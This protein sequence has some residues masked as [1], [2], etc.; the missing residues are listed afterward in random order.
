MAAI[1][2][3]PQCVKI[4]YDNFY[5]YL[6]TINTS[7]YIYYL[8]QSLMMCVLK[9]FFHF[10]T[11]SYLC[12]IFMLSHCLTYV[13]HPCYLIAI[14]EQ[15]ALVTY[16]HFLVHVLGSKFFLMWL[17]DGHP[18]DNSLRDGPLDIQKFASGPSKWQEMSFSFF[19]GSFQNW[20]TKGVSTSVL[21][22]AEIQWR[23]FRTCIYPS[24]YDLVHPSI[25]CMITLE[26]FFS[27]FF[28]NW[29]GHSSG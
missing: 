10:F 20:T 14:W 16:N 15:L 12:H 13:T 9:I 19:L 4:R 29:K 1:L 3:Q 8:T 26:I 22:P 11:G 5:S 2:Y 27:N 28:K 6:G 24:V 25:L 23:S 7:W 21:S 17:T 18:C